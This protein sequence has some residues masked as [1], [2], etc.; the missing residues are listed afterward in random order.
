MGI[1]L[2]KS[3]K[4]TYAPGEVDTL[5]MNDKAEV[6]VLYHKQASETKPDYDDLTKEL[7]SYEVALPESL[8]MPDLSKMNK[9]YAYAQAYCTRVSTIEI[10]SI[11]NVANWEKVCNYMQGF[12]KDKESILWISEEV[13]DLSNSK[14]QEAYVYNKLQ[15]LHDKLGEFKEHLAEANAFKNIV[16]T[17][18]N[19]LKSVIENITRQIKVLKTER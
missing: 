11:K 6:I 15:K 12:I 19:D 16:A 13:K 1:K 7:E 2:T 3:K 18:K 10:I 14:M 8:S 9:L 5:N 17:K 4:S